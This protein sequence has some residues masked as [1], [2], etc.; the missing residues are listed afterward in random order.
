[1]AHV[2]KGKIPTMKAKLPN[3]EI[4]VY[5]VHL[6]GGESRRVPTEEVA[7]KC[8]ALAPDSF[9]WVKYPQ[10]PDKDVV[11][12]GLV[13]ARKAKNGVLL[14]GRAGRGRGQVQRTKVGPA[15]DGWMLTQAGVRWIQD[16]RERVSSELQYREV[17]DHRQENL[18]KLARIKDHPV[19]QKFLEKPEGFSPS[20]G[21]MAELFRCRVDA[22]LQTWDKR[23]QAAG[24]LAQA[25]NDDGV[26]AF[27]AKCRASVLCQMGV[28]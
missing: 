9:S 15:V 8:F 16:N 11:R 26:M 10:Y 25:L 12:F 6:L 5:A 1:M 7:V 22:D 3:W 23:F 17:S 24:N 14:Q 13:D 4:A 2:P 20:L 18:H 19:F 28:Q 21:E 27:L